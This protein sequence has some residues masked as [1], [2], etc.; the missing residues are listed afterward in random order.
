MYNKIAKIDADSPD[1]QF[2]KTLSACGMDNV[3][4]K[5]YIVSIT[6]SLEEYLDSII[7]NE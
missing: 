2:Q 4:T 7:E 6:D 3:L 1:T 5:S